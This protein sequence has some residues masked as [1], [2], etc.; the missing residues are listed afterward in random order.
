MRGS[1]IRT[2]ITTEGAQ[3]TKRSHHQWRR[4]PNRTTGP[5]TL[6]TALRIPST[7]E[8][9]YGKNVARKA[10]KG[11]QGRIPDHI[12]NEEPPEFRPIGDA[13]DATF[14][15]YRLDDPRINHHDIVSIFRYLRPQML[16]L[17]EAHPNT[18]VFLNIH[19]TMFQ[20]SSGE[21]R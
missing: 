7:G 5:G 3:G 16:R 20:P 4:K 21:R 2:R 15:E 10:S 14:T 13:L 6:P 12:L 11:V 18:K 8:K 1:V 17:I 9:A 19:V